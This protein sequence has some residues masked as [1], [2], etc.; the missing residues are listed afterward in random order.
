M[1]DINIIR[2]SHFLR[3][4]YPQGLDLDGVVLD[5][6]HFSYDGPTLK[7]YIQSK[8]LPESPPKKWTSQYNT[9][10]IELELFE[11]SL[12]EVRRWGRQNLCDVKILEGDGLLKVDIKGEDCSIE[13]QTKWVYFKSISPFL[14][15]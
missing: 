3:N 15:D 6:I 12:V 8:K 5:S 14:T 9:V 13:V 1:I 2:E 7:L 4:L 11:T 10:R